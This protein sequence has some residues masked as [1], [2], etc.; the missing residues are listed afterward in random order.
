[1]KILVAACLTLL[2]SGCGSSDSGPSASEDCYSLISAYCAR[3]QTCSVAAG[4]TTAAF[5]AQYVA[6]CKGAASTTLDCSRA[7]RMLGDPDACKAEI[8]A[9]PC[10]FYTPSD[11]PLPASCKAI[12]GYK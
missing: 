10:S 5:G 8:N 2:S 3:A 1:M 6:N 12:V 11:F 7:V 4:E 9:M